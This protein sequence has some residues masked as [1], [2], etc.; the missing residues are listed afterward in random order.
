[1]LT[2][3]CKGKKYTWKN[4]KTVS[5][6]CHSARRRIPQPISSHTIRNNI[7]TAVHTPNQSR[8]SYCLSFHHHGSCFCAPS[9]YDASCVRENCLRA[10]CQRTIRLKPR[11]IRHHMSFRRKSCGR[12]HGRIRDQRSDVS[13]ASSLSSSYSIVS[14]CANVARQGREHTYHYRRAS[15]LRWH[16][17]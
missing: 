2:R 7:F 13:C 12:R 6:P 3:K 8:L 14:A 11:Q 17:Q 10:S 16:L 5:V 1:M 9:S 15:V 4:E